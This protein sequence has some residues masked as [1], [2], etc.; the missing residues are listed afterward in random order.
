MPLRGSLVLF[1][2][3]LDQIGARDFPQLR[4]W[5]RKTETELSP[6]FS[7]PEALVLTA[8]SRLP[9]RKAPLP[10]I[11][12]HLGRIREYGQEIGNHRGEP[13][14]RW[15]YFQVLALLFMEMLLTRL[16]GDTTGFLADLNAFLSRFS[17]G[18]RPPI[19]PFE[20]NDLKKIAF[21]M[22]TGSGKTLLLH[23]NYRQMRRY[24]PHRWDNILL[25][26]PNE[27][28][29]RQHYREA[30]LSGLK[31]TMYEGDPTRLRLHRGEM[32]I[33][34]IH[35][36]RENS[37]GG[38]VSLDIAC[39]EGRNLV[40]IDEG[41]KG[42]KSE[43]QRWKQLR[44]SL[45]ETG[46]ILEY[47]ATFGQVIGK[48]RFLL[49]EYAKSILFDYSYEHFYRDGYGKAFQAVNLRERL[50]SG[51]HY[52]DLVL[53]AGLVSFYNQLRRYEEHPARAREYGVE[54]PLWVFVGS[55]VAGKK[56][57]SDVVRVVRYL[58]QV[59]ADP[60]RLQALLEQLRREALPLRESLSITPAPSPE[61]G[62]D[63]T[64]G[65]IC[66]KVFGGIGALRLYQF[67]GIEGEIGLK[68]E[69]ARD[70]FGVIH[71]GN[72]AGLQK[73]LAAEGVNIATD[74]FGDSL[75]R[76]IEEADS[77]IHLLIGAK[78]FI[79]GW[80][81]WRVSTMTLMNMGKGEGPQIIQLFGRGVRLKGREMSLQRERASDP[82]LRVLQTLFIFGLNADYM[83][84]FL[85]AIQREGV[86]DF[87]GHVAEQPSIPEPSAPLSP[88]PSGKL[89]P[90]VIQLR[91]IPEMLRQVV[92]DIRPRLTR[93]QSEVPPASPSSHKSDQEG[94]SGK[95]LEHLWRHLP[96]ERLYL[97]ALKHKIHRR[98]DHLIIPRET[99][100]SI[101]NSPY[102]TVLARPE[103]LR[104]GSPSDLSRIQQLAERIVQRYMDVFY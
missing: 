91:P 23:V 90:P 12:T 16:Q 76:R 18:K 50:P 15:K 19:S 41:H 70:Y 72:S 79:E 93:V 14:F 57:D 26:T 95:E 75:F 47:S 6:N 30:R 61:A 56:L 45:A 24:F 46:M 9:S 59:L 58:R 42:Q 11:E 60:S 64:A 73:L 63:L 33:V 34:D 4:N 3:F 17:R 52:S 20:P 99:L 67:P 96:P 78:K 82:A 7:E 32:L 102:Y 48:N 68:V 10:E 104:L 77:P 38:G 71:V 13:G 98:Y 44:E 22:A 83:N 94:Y 55:R 43:E 31:A 27:G 84:A 51:E 40:F 69:G 39:F 87:A 62:N 89:S 80:N 8:L 74:Y 21:W 2:Y 88:T 100:F 97:A 25:I 86:A 37:G 35:K 36:L 101:L 28:L 85:I 103:Q 53:T 5:L 49:E 54:K 1:H 92:V 66:R 65:E 81:S 29:S